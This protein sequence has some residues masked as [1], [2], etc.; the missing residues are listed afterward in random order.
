MCCL[1]DIQVE[2][3]VWVFDLERCGL[4]GRFESGGHIG[5]EAAFVLAQNLYCTSTP[6][7]EGESMWLKW[8]FCE[9]VRCT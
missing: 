6:P 1:W 2:L 3:E 5:L 8:N 9:A 4:E 7:V